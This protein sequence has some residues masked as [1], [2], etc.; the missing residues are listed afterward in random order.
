[1]VEQSIYRREA[2]VGAA[3]IDEIYIFSKTDLTCCGSGSTVMTVSCRI[4]ISEY[5]A[6]VEERRSGGRQESEDWL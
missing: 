5:L 4:S 6:R 2:F 1:M 3:G